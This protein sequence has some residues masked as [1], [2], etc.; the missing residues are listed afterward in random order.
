MGFG[1]IRDN[2]K[3]C[4]CR[5]FKVVLLCLHG[6]LQ[7]LKCCQFALKIPASDFFV[8]QWCIS[9]CQRGLA[10]LINYVVCG[11]VTKCSSVLCV[12]VYLKYSVALLHLKVVF[13]VAAYKCLLT[14]LTPS[15]PVFSLLRHRSGAYWSLVL[16]EV[17]ISGESSSCGELFNSFFSFIFYELSPWLDLKA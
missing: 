7:K 2:L 5:L 15:L 10:W 17:W 6:Y 11:I 8:A 13:K 1:Q 12:Y 3:M 9:P 14:S 16:Q 4:G